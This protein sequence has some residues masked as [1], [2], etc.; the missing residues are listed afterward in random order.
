MTWYINVMDL[1][2]AII[3]VVLLLGWGILYWRSK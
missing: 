1:V 2:S 3:G